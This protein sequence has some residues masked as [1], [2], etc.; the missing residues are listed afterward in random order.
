M[1]LFI[2]INTLDSIVTNVAYDMHASTATS[3]SLFHL[4]MRIYQ[5]IIHSSV[6]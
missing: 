4:S 1:S 2:H 6:D 5:L 3:S